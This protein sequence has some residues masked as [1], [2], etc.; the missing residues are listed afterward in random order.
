M[1]ISHTIKH[2]VFR[3]TETEKRK[4][5]LGEKR[6]KTYKAW[7]ASAGIADGLSRRAV[8]VDFPNEGK[9]ERKSGSEE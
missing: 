1:Q 5:Y 9:G 3:E 4:L 8:T 2:T 6:G 7:I